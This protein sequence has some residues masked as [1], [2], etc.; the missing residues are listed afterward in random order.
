MNKASTKNR[1]AQLT[2]SA[3][4]QSELLALQ[5]MK[6]LLSA[7]S[8]IVLVMN[9]KGE[10]V[11]S[12]DLILKNKIIK[13]APSLKG[14]TLG[15]ALG[16]TKCINDITACGLIDYCN[17]CN[18]L[19]AI[20]ESI[21]TSFPSKK[22]A[23]LEIEINGI[24]EEIYL[25][26]T[27]AQL[28]FYNHK[29]TV[30]TAKD[31]TD[32]KRQ[33]VL[34]QAF[35]HD[36]INLAG[37]LDGIMESMESMSDADRARFIPSARRIGNS[38]V[39]EIVVHQEILKAENNSLSL[40]TEAYELD[41]LIGDSI[42]QIRHHDVAKGKNVYYK[43]NLKD[44]GIVTDKAI[45]NRILTNMLKNALESSKLGE[46]VTISALKIKNTLKIEVHN[47]Y[48]IPQNVQ[49]KIFQRS[50]STKGKGR[51]I[52]TYSMKLLGEKY[53]RGQV[54]FESTPENGTIFSV[55][56]PQILLT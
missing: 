28:T 47:N 6:N 22:E 41:E 5:E 2:K 15:A 34:Q 12:N 25:E 46:I 20:T 43:T 51:G 4:R 32:K 16:C 50:F 7:I 42:E 8:D 17:Y 14:K 24:T 3:K 40:K 11:L 18:A 55:Q 29:Y 9:N 10:I 39:D 45:L 26:V 23:D 35:F 36:I 56:V 27:A 21:E 19:K 38:L 33:D 48:F 54:E 30:F 13:S 52:G 44:E 53:L 31:I 49:N 37:S 1:S